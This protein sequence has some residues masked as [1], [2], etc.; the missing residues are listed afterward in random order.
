MLS[1]TADYYKSVFIMMLH[2]FKKKGPYQNVNE[3]LLLDDKTRPYVAHAVVDFSNARGIIS[4]PHPTY[5]PDL[6]PCDFW[7]FLKVKFPLSGWKFKSNYQF[8]KA[9]KARLQE[10]EKDGLA[11]VYKII[12]HD[13]TALNSLVRNSVSQ[14]TLH[15]NTSLYE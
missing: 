14:T 4:V 13:V 15:F 1:L 9:V 8:I 6:A 2:D 5:S 11:F 10:L 7:L 12:V 3:V